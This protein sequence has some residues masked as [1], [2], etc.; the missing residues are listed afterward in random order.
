MKIRLGTRLALIFG[1]LTAALLIAQSILLVLRVS[2]NVESLISKSAGETAQARAD[3]IG[4]WLAGHE[5]QVSLLASL[6]AFR[7]GNLE[8]AVAFLRTRE[9]SMNPEHLLNLYAEPSGAY[10]TQ[11]GAGG[12]VSDRDYFIDILRNGKSMTVGAANISRSTGK[13]QIVIAEGVPG[14][15]GRPAGLVAASIALD[16]VNAIAGGIALA[17]GG[18]GVVFQKDGIVIGHPNEKYLLELNL[19]D[20]EKEGFQGLSAVAKQAVLGKAGSG[21]YRDPAGVDNVLFYA[22]IPNSPGWVLGATVPT[23]TLFA[24]VKTII[25][26]IAILT[27]V[28]LAAVVLVS[29]TA[30]GSIVKPIRAAAAAVECMAAGDLAFTSLRTEEKRKLTARE[31]EIGAMGRALASTSERLAGI[32]DAIAAAAQAVGRGAAEINSA[33]RTLAEGASQQAAAAEQVS[34]SM[35]EMSSNVQNTT[36]NAGETERIAVKTAANSKESG[37]AVART[38]DAMK[39]IAQRILIVEEIARQTNLL[40]LNAAIEAAR[41][42]D[43]GKGFAVVASEVRK[44]AERSQAAARDIG[45]LS[46]KSMA[47]AENAGGRLAAIVPEIA[48][49]TDLIQEIGSALREQR[50][51]VDQVSAA[52]NQLDQV[53]QRNAAA[54]EELSGSADS[55]A[56]NAGELIERISFFKR[57]EQDRPLALPASGA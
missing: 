16:T 19:L 27:A 15:G 41:A 25:A 42:G 10:R 2:E 51:G 34:A 56:A 17:E 18:I 47:V 46:A 24:F 33:A 44:L 23:A 22:P 52:T 40:A 28:T 8:N 5:A 7:S 49:T 21:R 12:S 45:E 39:E 26:T 50:S 57:E 54:A 13:R 4:R 55:L 48:R 30:A 36:D 29:L 3:E 38:V 43:A 14:A 9:R 53:V 32:V 20:S 11:T 35:E 31:D 37:E 1:G 6:D